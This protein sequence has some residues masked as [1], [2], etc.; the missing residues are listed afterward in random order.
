MIRLARRLLAVRPPK[1]EPAA[2]AKSA[3]ITSEVDLAIVGAGVAGLAAA[4]TARA[5]GLSVALLEAQPRI[6]GRAFTDTLDIGGGA[7]PL[8]WDRGCHWLHQARQNPFTEL[9]D[10]LGFRYRTESQETRIWL[11]DRWAGTR[12]MA[13]RREAA[14]R[15]DRAVAAAAEAGRD[16]AMADVIPDLGRWHG[17]HRQF[18]RAV[19]GEDPAGTSAVDDQR[20]AETGD[21]WPVEA[22]FGALVAAWARTQP[23][24]TGTPVRRIDRHGRQLRVETDRGTLQ[25]RAA[26][27]TPSTD[28]LLSGA[29]TLDPPMPAEVTDA[30]A[31]VPLGAANKVAL[32]FDRDVLRPGTRD[33]GAPAR[34]AARLQLPDPPVRPQHGD[35]A[36]G[37]SA[38]AR[39]RTRRAEGDDR[40]RL[41]PVGLDVRRRGAPG[42]CRERDHGLGPTP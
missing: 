7:A 3:D 36:F 34:R 10:E 17:V 8:P 14:E 28:A 23:V 33:G 24:I 16:L 39:P 12:E 4:K 6:G 31:G 35:R 13:E 15:A 41:R 40:V 32:A 21:N 5:R 27:L 9:A 18:L 2:I 38:G 20:Y 19:T 30:L 1:A 37:R 26:I 11:G 29:L 42:A 22:G 25:A